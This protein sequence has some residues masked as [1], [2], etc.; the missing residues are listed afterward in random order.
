[1]DKKEKLL[2]IRDKVI[3]FNKYILEYGYNED[4]E[5][6]INKKLDEFLEFIDK[7]EKEIKNEKG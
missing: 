5:I 4:S 1:M 2:D 7:Y 3:N 6:F